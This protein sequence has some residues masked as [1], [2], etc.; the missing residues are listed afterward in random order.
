MH[1]TPKLKKFNNSFK[2]L[3]Y[4]VLTRLIFYFFNCF[5]KITVTTDVS[6]SQ[7]LF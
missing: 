3:I 6:G 4:R 5:Q 1:S 7:I 2:A